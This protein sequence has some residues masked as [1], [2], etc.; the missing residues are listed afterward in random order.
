MIKTLK[1]FISILK[2]IFYF[3]VGL[4]HTTITKKRDYTF[5]LIVKITLI[6]TLFTIVLLLIMTNELFLNYLNN[7]K[8]TADGG[9]FHD[10]IN[11][12]SN[13]IIFNM[14]FKTLG[15]DLTPNVSILLA[16]LVI[17][18]SLLVILVILTSQLKNFLF[19][20]LTILTSLIIGI[21][22]KIFAN[23]FLGSKYIV[24][25][26]GIKIFKNLTDDEKIVYLKELYL[27]YENSLKKNQFINNFKWDAS[28]ESEYLKKFKDISDPDLI[29][30]TFNKD[31][32]QLTEIILTKG[33]I[34]DLIDTYLS[35]I[36]IDKRK[37][38][39]N[40]IYQNIVDANLKGNI[41][42]ENY[43]LNYIDIKANSFDWSLLT[44]SFFNLVTS[45]IFIGILLTA[46]VV[47]LGYITISSY[48]SS[49][50]DIIIKSQDNI[51]E[52]INKTGEA[53]KLIGDSANLS[54][55]L[56]NNTANLASS[57]VDGLEN[58]TNNLSEGLN[59]AKNSIDDLSEAMDRV[60][61][62]LAEDSVFYEVQKNFNK[63]LI[64]RL[65]LIDQQLS[66][67]LIDQNIIKDSVSKLQD[68]ESSQDNFIELISIRL[69]K[70]IEYINK[71]L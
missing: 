43:I 61:N 42:I 24:N 44:D 46:C 32:E 9:Y 50:N 20:P 18:Y 25:F 33:Q 37:D 62:R 66:K 12:V 7:L 14:C 23:V 4:S 21:Y 26:A 71:T 17:S 15:I 57:T 8:I 67:L 52:H 29:N 39:V 54:A 58:I 34:Y 40:Q 41:E 22:F 60:N 30:I 13:N 36:S 65:T 56:V 49:S 10:L 2:K 19:I 48:L 31:L 47:T 69:T 6:F 38:L 64:D 55:N 68:N 59:L 28:K 1:L 51:I 45:P 53:S 5:S 16:M 63:N 35:T 3:I 11:I 27:I 70:I